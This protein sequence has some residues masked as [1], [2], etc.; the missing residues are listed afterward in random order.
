MK[1]LVTISGTPATTGM[2]A[3]D[4]AFQLGK[5]AIIWIGA[6][7]ATRLAYKAFENQSRSNIDWNHPAFKNLK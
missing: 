4:V 6:N 5:I 1:K 2:V 3:K 7:V